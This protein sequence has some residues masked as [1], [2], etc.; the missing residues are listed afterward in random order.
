M[1][2]DSFKIRLPAPFGGHGGSEKRIRA[3]PSYP[4]HRGETLMQQKLL[5]L[6]VAGVLSAPLAVQAQNVQIY[7]QLTPSFDIIDNG[8]ESGNFIQDNNSRLGFK[9]S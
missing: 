4:R 8:D 5:A 6:A 7:G 3:S 2:P 1:P 9:G